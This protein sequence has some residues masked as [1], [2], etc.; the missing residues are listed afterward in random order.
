MA[1]PDLLGDGCLNVRDL[2]GL[3][4]EDGV[5]TRFRSCVRAYGIR[6]PSAV[7]RE[8]PLACGSRTA[9]DL[10]GDHERRDDPP[11][12]PPLE[13]GHAPFTEANEHG[14]REIEPAVASAAAATDLA[15]AGRDVDPISLERFTSRVGAALD[16]VARAPEGGVAVHSVGGRDRTGLLA[17]PLLRV[18]GVARDDVAADH[19]LSEGRLRLRHERWLAAAEIEEGR[20]R[21]R[22][23]ARA[24]AEAVA[25]MLDELERPYGSVG[26]S[27][28]SAGLSDD[29]LAL[30]RARLRG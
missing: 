22:W 13:V 19:A 14:A 4:M 17:A 25:G 28:R 7:R 15:I 24:P 5:E 3:P 8:R 12:E 1:A 6:Q 2:G 29:D 30:A 21:L 9:I 10:R 27:R 26:V 18:V 16:A 20:E 23:S 11:A